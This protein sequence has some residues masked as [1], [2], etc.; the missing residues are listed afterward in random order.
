MKPT[1]SPQSQ[2]GENMETGT[3]VNALTIVFAALCIFAIAYRFYGLFIATKVLSLNE[4]R[5]TPAVKL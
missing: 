3:G 4:A 2:P 1:K 5:E